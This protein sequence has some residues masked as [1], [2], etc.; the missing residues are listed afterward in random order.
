MSKNINYIK[1]KCKNF[2]HLDL[3]EFV[4]VIAFSEKNLENQELSVQ[5]NSL[6]TPLTIASSYMFPSMYNFCNKFFILSRNITNSIFS[7][8]KPMKAWL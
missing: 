5:V 1:F 8:V 2:R 4:W 7:Q 3:N 6:F